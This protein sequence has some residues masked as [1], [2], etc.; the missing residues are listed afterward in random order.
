MN[1]ARYS[2]HRGGSHGSQNS[3]NQMHEQFR[4]SSVDSPAGYHPGRTSR[5][6]LRGDQEPY[7][8]RRV[9]KGT[10]HKGQPGGM[11]PSGDNYTQYEIDNWEVDHGN[12]WTGGYGPYPGD[13]GAPG[14][15]AGPARLNSLNSQWPMGMQPVQQTQQQ[16]HN[17]RQF[18]EHQ[19]A[20]Q[21][22]PTSHQRRGHQHHAALARHDVQQHTP[23]LH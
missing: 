1:N 8:I 15:S 7:R 12:Q 18:H 16:A 9:E 11:Q 2:G 10:T 14:Y 6:E 19:Q 22:Q 4:S 3:P 17:M 5:G 23:S 13:L 21:R 20:Q